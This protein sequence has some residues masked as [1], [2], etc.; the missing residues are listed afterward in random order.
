MKYLFLFFFF[1]SQY[2]FAKDITLSVPKMTCPSCA[3]SIEGKLSQLKGVSDIKIDI[4]KR[5]VSITTSDKS[6]ISIAQ[7]VEAIKAVGFSSE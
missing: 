1:V 5:T 4:G 7:A 2:A 3:S 6:K